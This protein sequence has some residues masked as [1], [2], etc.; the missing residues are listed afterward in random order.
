VNQIIFHH[1]LNLQID[2]G[3]LL[4]VELRKDVLRIVA[5]ISLGKR[6]RA[7]RE[8]FKVR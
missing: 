6:L 7:T 8:L 4:A 3:Q 1:V 5:K 2:S